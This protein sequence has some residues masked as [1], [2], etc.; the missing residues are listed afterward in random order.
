MTRDEHVQRILTFVF[1]EIGAQ[2]GPDDPFYLL[3][4][5]AVFVL[6][7]QAVADGVREAIHEHAISPSTN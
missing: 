7:D 2:T 4:G 3:L 6:I 5:S 1:E